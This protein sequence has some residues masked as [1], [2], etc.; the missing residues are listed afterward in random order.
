MSID[1][2]HKKWKQ[3]MRKEKKTYAMAT[4]TATDGAGCGRTLDTED[5]GLAVVLDNVK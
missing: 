5:E 2:R 1:Q 4:A 3:E